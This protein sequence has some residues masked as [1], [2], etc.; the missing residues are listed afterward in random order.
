MFFF[1][2]MAA[3]SRR[4]EIFLNGDDDHAIQKRSFESIERMRQARGE[5]V[6]LLL[7][8]ME[9]VGAIDDDEASLDDDGIRV[10]HS[11]SLLLCFVDFI[12]A[13]VQIVYTKRPQDEEPEAYHIRT[14]ASVLA[15]EDVAKEALLYSYNTVAS[16][17]SAKLTPQQA[18]QISK[19]LGVLQVIPNMK[20]QLHTGPRIEMISQIFL[21]L[22]SYHM[23]NFCCRTS[24]CSSGCPQLESSAAYRSWDWEA[25]LSLFNN[26]PLTLA[27]IELLT[28]SPTLSSSINKFIKYFR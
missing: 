20:V 26:L 7:S 25:A 10:S 17:F 11:F 13:S 2:F 14:L 8:G 16:G 19:L 24:R 9:T 6:A 23:L 21:S 12:S 28:P 18:E 1:F 5:G 4:K 15:S 27:N 3:I 22:Y